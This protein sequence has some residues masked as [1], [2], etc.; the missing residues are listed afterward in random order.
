MDMRI[1]LHLIRHGRTLWNEEHRYLGHENQG[2]LVEGRQ[3]LLPLRERFCTK[4]FV[5]IYCSDLLRCRQTLNVILSDSTM[6]AIPDDEDPGR[7]IPG[8]EYDLRLRELDFGDWEGNTYEDLK[9]DIS[10]R[11]WID[12]PAEVTPPNGESW[13]A[14][15]S[16][17]QAFLTGLY[18]DLKELLHVEEDPD[19][20]VQAEAEA[21]AAGYGCG[22]QRIE[23]DVLVVTHGGVIRQI[24]A[25]TLPHTE[26]WETQVSPGEELK[27]QL[28]WDEK[29]WQGVRL[30]E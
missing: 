5:R 6:S 11:C 14:F 12:N 18:L 2:I 13:E 27:L 16:R 4:Q 20:L 28:T 19:T 8:V 29:R 17:I 9:S 15:C 24:A 22:T 7:L 1:T 21:E 26:F 10:Y 3:Q 25:A 30:S 23:L